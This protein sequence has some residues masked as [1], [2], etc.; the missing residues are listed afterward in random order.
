M[1]RIKGFQE[2]RMS[3]DIQTAQTFIDA[4]IDR[5]R[6]SHS[7]ADRF[8]LNHYSL[9]TLEALMVEHPKML[10]LYGD[11]MRE[12]RDV[13]AVAALFEGAPVHAEQLRPIFD[14]RPRLLETY[15]S[16]ALG[17]LREVE[18]TTQQRDEPLRTRFGATR[19]STSAD[20]AVIEKH[21]AQVAQWQTMLR[22]KLE[23]LPHREWRIFGGV[24]TLLLQAIEHPDPEFSGVC[25]RLSPTDTSAYDFLSHTVKISR[26]GELDSGAKYG[27]YQHFG[28][29]PRVGKIDERQVIEAFVANDLDDSAFTDAI[30]D[31]AVEIG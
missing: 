18:P 19:I 20:L 11:Y 30:E 1:D 21:L 5:Q 27:E 17:E 2:T 31:A 28:Y 25:V 16:F 24:A 12:H 7:F 29:M 9:E 6:N 22:K 4:I 8:I 23:G 26:A 15:A 3:V 13:A 10:E 14:G